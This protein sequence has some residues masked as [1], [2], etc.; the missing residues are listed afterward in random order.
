[1]FFKPKPKESALMFKRVEE[2]EKLASILLAALSSAAV[3]VTYFGLAMG[4][5]EAGEGLLQKG[6]ALLVAL[7]FGILNWLGYHFIFGLVDR[8]R[9]H[10][11]NAGAMAGFVFLAI[12]SIVDA[13]LITQAIAGAS[14]S[15]MSIVDVAS[16][17][18]ERRNETTESIS[19]V[20]KLLPAIRA[21]VG[22]F[23]ELEQQE[24]NFGVLSG[25]AKPGKVSSALGQVSTL[26]TG[27]ADQ[28]EAGIAEAEGIEAEVTTS[29]GRIKEHA[30]TKAPISGRL[31]ATS[32][33]ADRI[34]ELLARLARYDYRSSVRASLETLSN[35][36]PV[37]TS[38]RSEFEAVQNDEMG[39]VREMAKPVADALGGSLADLPETTSVTEKRKVRPLTPS[40]ATKHYWLRILPE[41]LL[42]IFFDLAPFF[43]V[44]LLTAGRREAE[45]MV[46]DEIKEGE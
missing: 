12:L 7:A 20:K 8:M 34:D 10:R 35:L 6:L 32:R 31:E 37:P 25:S 26:L 44:V 15:Q 9:S 36:F 21:E 23:S 2:R 17:Y 24:I 3:A 18:E 11:L 14:A 42:G 19:A 28:L 16:Y 22:R 41:W 27:L 13:Q 43:L 38:A 39:R 5:S 33:E 1:V 29:L 40:D 45:Q 4:I 30:Y 46:R